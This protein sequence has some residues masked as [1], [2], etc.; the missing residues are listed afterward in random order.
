MKIYFAFIIL[1]FYLGLATIGSAQEFP[2]TFP[3]DLGQETEYLDSYYPAYY[4]ISDDLLP[5]S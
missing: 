2:Y 3:Q 1:A 5:T 4:L